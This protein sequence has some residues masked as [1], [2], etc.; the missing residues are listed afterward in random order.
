MSTAVP[1]AHA[2]K[3]ASTRELLGQGAAVQPGVDPDNTRCRLYK[4][5]QATDYWLLG[6]LAPII[7]LVCVGNVVGRTQQTTLRECD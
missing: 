7:G 3:Q 2:I 6:I 4:L 1:Q 5:F